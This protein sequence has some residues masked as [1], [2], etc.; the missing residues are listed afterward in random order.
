[1][2]RY[3]HHGYADNAQYWIGE[4]Y[5]DLKQYKAA[6]REF[7]RVVERYPHGNKV[8]EAM[9]KIGVSQLATGDG[10]EGR[11]QLES[12]RRMYPKHPA[13]R[14][15]AARLAQADEPARTATVAAEV[16]PR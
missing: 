2:A 5:Y 11:Q 10:R 7:R 14:L 12:L 4:C 6:V 3:P 15:A 9:L 16:S 1:M 13:S 8:P